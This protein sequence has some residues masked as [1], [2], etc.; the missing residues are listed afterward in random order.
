[1]SFLGD[2]SSRAHAFNARVIVRDQIKDQFHLDSQ[3]NLMLER[4]P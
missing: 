3:Q 4:A 1:M 2:I